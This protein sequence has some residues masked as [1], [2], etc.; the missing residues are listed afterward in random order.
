MFYNYYLLLKNCKKVCISEVKTLGEEYRSV[1]GVLLCDCLKE[2]GSYRE[3]I[4]RAT[5]LHCRPASCEAS[6]CEHEYEH[7]GKT[8]V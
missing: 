6:L 2:A 1:T 8:S 3:C 4:Q 5:Q 7:T